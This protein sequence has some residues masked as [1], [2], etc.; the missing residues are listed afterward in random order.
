MG[1]CGS[2]KIRR[3]SDIYY[4]FYDFPGNRRN[5]KTEVKRILCFINNYQLMRRYGP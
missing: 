5:R 4:E 1:A 3:N 2:S